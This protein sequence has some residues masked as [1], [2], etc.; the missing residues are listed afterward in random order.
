MNCIPS[1]QG[2]ET[3]RRVAP[4]LTELPHTSVSSLRFRRGLAFSG[5]YGGA[6]GQLE[7]Q[8]LLNALGVIRQSL[9]KIYSRTQA[10]D[11]FRIGGALRRLLA[12]P[13]QVFDR[14]GEVI[15]A[16]VMMRQIAQ[17]IVESIGVKRLYRHRRALVQQLAALDQQR[18]IRDL[19]RQRMLEGVFDSGG[20][21]LFVDELGQLQVGE[22]A[23]QL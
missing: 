18:V 12:R 4:A 5:D 13:P 7:E 10:T 20:S 21:G 22:H 9:E 11:P 14:L 1:T 8:F 3:L 16:S 15:A 23:L 6:N 2:G 17:T 19:L